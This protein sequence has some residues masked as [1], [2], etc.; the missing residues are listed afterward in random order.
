M[1]L[2][3]FYAGLILLI[4]GLA[5]PLGIVEANFFKYILYIGIIAFA[6][7]VLMLPSKMKQK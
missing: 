3:V 4:M 5:H 2:F 6:I 1:R 7:G